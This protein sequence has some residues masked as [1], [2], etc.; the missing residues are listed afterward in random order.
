MISQEAKCSR[1][2]AYAIL[3][4]GQKYG[5]TV[6][7]ICKYRVWELTA[8]QKRNLPALIETRRKNKRDNRTW[9]VQLLSERAGVPEKEM[10]ARYKS[11][12][13][14]GYTI[15][16]FV[17][18]DIYMCP[19]DK[20]PDLVVGKGKKEEVKKADYADRD[21]QEEVKVMDLKSRIMAETGW[22]EGRYNY[23]FLRTQCLTRCSAEDYF[24]D[25]MYQKSDEENA[26]YLTAE[27][28]R[29]LWFKYAGSKEGIAIFKNKDQFDVVFKEYLGRTVFSTKGLTCEDFVK[30]IEGLRKVAYKPANR[31]MGKGFTVINVNESPEQN[32][33][34]FELIRSLP[35]GIVEEYLIQHEDI[36]SF[37]SDAINTIRVI[38]I[39]NE[40]VS[41]IFCAVMRIG[42]K[43]H[44]DNW[45]Q[46]GISV[47]IDLDTGCLC[48]NGADK[49]GKI[50]EKHPVTGKQF[51]GFQIPSWDKVKET[52]LN[53]ALLVPEMGF[54]G[55]DVAVT[56][57][58]EAVLIEG[59]HASSAALMQEPFADAHIGLKPMVLPYVKGVYWE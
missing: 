25:K 34:A 16:A 18:H 42:V 55:W 20:I 12:R 1:L 14:K 46:G 52:C 10:L 47:G 5:I 48:T 59:N 37:Y 56:H 43:G 30:N 28:R 22:S 49:D 44:I 29:R 23:E 38:T 3:K 4:D 11:A 54:I 51:K 2:K 33:K 9:L 27:L 45:S 50:Y 35:D 58:G 36:A 57:D 31:N 21:D 40:G 26:D 13:K 8:E 24:L 19:V 39:V 17:F 32:R 15:K 41:H 6:D 53:A 7:Q